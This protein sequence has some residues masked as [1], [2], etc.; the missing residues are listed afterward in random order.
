MRSV[1][2]NRLIACLLCAALMLSLVSCGKKETPENA[3][4]N[5]VSDSAGSGTKTDGSASGG[6]AQGEKQPENASGAATPDKS[7]QSG[8]K[9]PAAGNKTPTAGNKTGTAGAGTALNGS[10]L[11]ANVPA[12]GTAQDT[13]AAAQPSGSADASAAAQGAAQDKSGDTSAEE[14][15]VSVGAEKDLLAALTD[16]KVSKINIT[17]TIKVS[18][19]I[20]VEGS[21]TVTGAKI[22]AEKEMDAIYEVREGATLT[23]KECIIDGASLAKCAVKNEGTVQLANVEISKTTASALHND[24]AMTMAH[25]KITNC[26]SSADGAGVYNAGALTVEDCIFMNN[27][28]KKDGGA[29]YNTEYSKLKIA[30]SYFKNNKADNGGSV[31]IYGT[32]YTRPTAEISNCEFVGDNSS[33]YGA[34]IFSRGKLLLENS[35]FD[36]GVSKKGA[37]A[38]ANAAGELTMRFCEAKNCSSKATGGVFRLTGVTHIEDCVFTNNTSVEGGGVLYSTTYATIFLERCKFYDN[39]SSKGGAAYTYG[40]S[41]SASGVLINDCEFKNNKASGYGGALYTMSIM[42]MN[43]TVFDNCQSTE[44]AGG[45]ITNA[46]G[47]IKMENC[48]F[49]NCKSVASGGA[50]R[51]TGLIEADNVLFERNYAQSSGGAFYC[52]ANATVDMRNTT[53]RKNSTG[54]DGGAVY[55]YATATSK[56]NIKMTG[57]LFEN[58]TAPGNGGAIRNNSDI[59]LYSCTFR[60]N[61]AENRGGALYNNAWG[62]ISLL[63]STFEDN[64]SDYR[65]GAIYN[66]NAGAEDEVETEED[67]FKD[68]TVRVRLSGCTLKN[69]SAK[70]FGGGIFTGGGLYLNK[71]DFI[72]CESL[73]SQG[74]GLST[75]VYGDVTM[76]NCGFYGCTTPGS[77]AAIR[78]CSFLTATD[79]TFKDNTA[80]GE[81]LP[82]GTFTH[83]GAVYVMYQGG[84]DMKRCTFDSNFSKNYGGALHAHGGMVDGHASTAD[85]TLDQCTFTN[86]ESLRGGALSNYGRMTVSNCDIN[87]NTANKFGGA[88]FNEGRDYAVLKITDGTR[89]TDNVCASS[90]SGIYSAGDV[91]LENAIVKNNESSVAGEVYIT[92]DSA[93]E[94]TVKGGESDIASIF[95]SDGKTVMVASS[96]KMPAGEK[97]ALCTT[98]K[99]TADMISGAGSVKQYFAL[100]GGSQ[101]IGVETN[102]ATGREEVVIKEAEHSVQLGDGVTG[103]TTATYGT[104]YTFTVPAGEYEVTATVDGKKVSVS[105]NGTTYKIDGTVIT[106]D[107]SISITELI[108]PE[109]VDDSDE[110]YI[111]A[112]GS[113]A[114]K[115]HGTLAEVLAVAADGD[116]VYLCSDVTVDSDLAID[117]NITLT[118]SG[119]SALK[120]TVAADAQLNVSAD[121]LITGTHGADLVI[122]GDDEVR[123][124]PAITVSGSGARLTL[125]A[126]LT[127][128][129]MNNQT[130]DNGMGSAL[131]GA[132]YV[133]GGA[134]TVSGAT[135]KGNT[136][137]YRGGAIYADGGS[138]TVTSGSFAGNKAVDTADSENNKVTGGGAIYAANGCALQISGGTFSANET[139]GYGG[140]IRTE[141]S[142]AAIDGAVFENCRSDRFGGAIA[143]ASSGSVNI[144]NTEFTDNYAKSQAGAVYVN[145]AAVTIGNGVKASGN[146]VG[147]ADNTVYY[148][149]GTLQLAGEMD[150]GI[151]KLVDEKAI[152]LVGAVTPAD[153]AAAAATIEAA[154]ALYATNPILTNKTYVS[155][156]YESFALADRGYMIRRDGTTAIDTCV[157]KI[158]DVKYESFADAMADANA[159]DDA[160]ATV[161]INLLKDVAYT[162]ATDLSVDKNVQISISTDVTISGPVTFN[163]QGITRDTYL[164]SVEKSGVLTLKDGAAVKDVISTAGSNGAIR[165]VG[166]LNLDN[167]TVSGCK[168]PRGAVYAAAGGKITVKNSSFANNTATTS[169]GAIFVYAGDTTVSSAAIENSTFTDNTAESRGGAIY[170]TGAAADVVIRDSSFTGSTIDSGANDVSVNN[171]KLS[172]AGTV[173][174]DVIE[175]TAGMKVTLDEALTVAKTIKIDS[176]ALGKEVLGGSRV[177]ECYTSFEPVAGGCTIDENGVLKSTNIA[178]I[179]SVSYASLDE[180]L[181]AAN[182]VTIAQTINLLQSVSYKTPTTL[183]VNKNVQISTE[184]DVTISG[185][186]TL[187]GKSVERTTYM[188]VVKAGGRLTFADGAALK[189]IV[190]TASSNGVIRVEGKGE[191][192]FNGATVSGCTAPRGAVYLAAGGK[193]TAKDTTFANNTATTNGGAIFVYGGD[194]SVSSAEIENCIFMDNTASTRGGAIFVTGG[195]AAQAEI[196]DSSFSGNKAGSAAND[197]AVNNG[198]LSLSGTV[199]MDAIDLTA[200]MTVALNDDLT[201]AAP[202]KI[203]STALGKAVLSGSRVADYYTSFEA[204]ADGCTINEKG[205]LK[206]AN[207]ASIGSVSYATLD[208][209]VD[210]ANAVTSAQTIKILQSVEYDTAT[211]LKVNK[212][213]QFDI[214]NDVTI[215]G[216]VTIDGQGAS[217][218]AVLFTVQKG[219]TLTLA[220]GAVLKDAVTTSSSNGVIRVVSGGTAAFDGATVSGCKA[221]RGAV[222]AAAGGT[223]TVKDSTFENNTATASGGAIYAYAGTTTATTVTVEGST[224]IGNTSTSHGG[225]VYMTGKPTTVTMTDCVI[226]DGEG[227]AYGTV[228]VVSGTL[229][230]KNCT[231]T[232]NTTANKTGTGVYLAANA[233]ATLDGCTVSGNTASGGASDYNEVY[234]IK[235]AS[236]TLKGDNTINRIYLGSGAAAVNLSGV[237]TG[238]ISFYN[239]TEGAQLLSG[240]TIAASL[241]AFSIEG[242]AYE[243][244]EEGF[245][246]DSAS[247]MSVEPIAYDPAAPI[248][249]FITEPDG[250]GEGETVAEV[251]AETAEETAE[252]AETVET[253]EAADEVIEQSPA[254]VQQDVIVPAAEEKEE[255]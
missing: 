67:E 197:I 37:G 173:S 187:D 210:A 101:T 32:G 181:E 56:S 242:G 250:I 198:K 65:G 214:A 81:N 141:A 190:T 96:Y 86:N 213:V 8:T 100:D 50:I 201:V 195:A 19:P 105:G 219:G 159:A 209:A 183:T 41:T 98:G 5:E 110:A 1:R 228:Y 77:G 23:L 205:V 179:G 247:L 73:E 193:T 221:P 215:S 44:S 46:A 113:T 151:V 235:G 54:K 131:G 83:G 167:V 59:K 132:I 192:A 227:G 69:N 16:P 208:A 42:E 29:I 109:D 117:K 145:S 207:T 184:N 28:A 85:V 231:V 199:A 70:D 203:D 128:S 112:A 189:D 246:V 125:G 115:A 185:P 134:V 172:L 148:Y 234:A 62:Y 126:A 241:A 236:L 61:S 33:T 120:L 75:T 153:G 175:L 18:E 249:E 43:N 25:V 34:S 99:A 170:M 68:V 180:A 121:V 20:I 49:T 133:N 63:D 84:A 160:A 123:T 138:V 64:S 202:I 15:A 244:N 211:T 206:S 137:S 127:V 162:E 239:V 17:Q 136:A 80:T 220:D 223:I 171:G 72:N 116:T 9:A 177:A 245:A 217:R 95:L 12:A 106:G 10:S 87:G 78:T 107:V 124:S 144:T 66:Y 104:D 166:T 196:K 38:V 248:E 103:E 93:A 108:V 146:K 58:N 27:T 253:V 188:I 35:T 118:T 55:Y 30:D 232:A 4:G 90:G 36:G 142:S 22:I 169:G 200:D 47:H 212:N 94:I 157:A 225:T 229:T 224:F 186:V 60:N 165:V 230:M 150:L 233:I 74:G 254:E 122:S 39:Y 204:L 111:A 91:Q 176:T 182:A 92:G 135:I 21:K 119:D 71:T 88:I 222:Y 156:S 149:S 6:A 102:P 140:A 76:D 24:G 139:G 237:V 174:M 114:A 130:K 48:S 178:S 51:N 252:T 13:A 45:A 154:C 191:V 226:K 3:P 53:F 243:I 216:P 155:S 2:L 240:S 164:F 158:G 238:D 14:G 251:T 57:C 194:V 79:C 218:T 89:I 82:D 52:S 7:G 255:A 11:S 40:S 163:G 143:T 31:A 26:K 129:G 161:V 152:T 168:A 147:T 97:T